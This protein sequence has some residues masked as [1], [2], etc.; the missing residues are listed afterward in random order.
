M[1]GSFD[2]RKPSKGAARQRAR[3]LRASLRRHDARY[4]AAD[5]PEISDATYDQRKRRLRKLERRFP[6][7]ATPRS[8]TQQV[9]SEPRQE[10]GTVQHRAPMLSLESVRNET[11]FR[12]FYAHCCARL[13]QAT[14]GVVAEPKYDGLSIELAYWRGELASAATR[15]DGRIGEDVTANVRTIRNLPLK[16]PKQAGL[17]IPRQLVVRGEIYLEKKAFA[18]VNRQRQ[19]HGETA[20]LSPRHAAASSVRQLDPKVTAGRPLKILFWE[21]VEH[22]GATLATHWQQLQALKALGLAVDRRVR[23]LSSANQA[24]RYFH[25]LERQRA[26]L[27]YEI[28]GTVFKVNDVGNQQELGLRLTNPRWAV[29]WKFAPLDD[30]AA[31]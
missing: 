2:R 27:P 15:G 17:V 4:H 3:K 14:I 31:E 30:R 22:S 5:A 10:F 12:E 26:G 25:R 7:L 23:L 24:V 1:S 21:L 19:Q 9:G 8:P 6:E 11:E 28:D 18:K 13:A 29:A 20:F 16:L